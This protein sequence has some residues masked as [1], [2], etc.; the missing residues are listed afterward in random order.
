MAPPPRVATNSGSDNNNAA[1]KRDGADDD[2]RDDFLKFERDEEGRPINS[3]G[4]PIAPPE[5]TWVKDMEEEWKATGYDE[6]F[7]DDDWD[8]I[9]PANANASNA[10]SSGKKPPPE[11]PFKDIHDDEWKETGFS[12]EAEEAEDNQHHDDIDATAHYSTSSSS[13]SSSA[14]AA[15]A[16]AAASQPSQSSQSAREWTAPV[17]DLTP[18]E[19]AAQMGFDPGLVQDEEPE[20]PPAVLLAGF[21]AEEIPRIRELLDELGGHDVPVLPVP[22]SHLEKPLAEALAIPEPDWENPRLHERFNQGGEFGS[23][24]V[25]IFSGLDRGEMATV[26]SAV[27]A[28]GLPRLLTV[29]ITGENLENT[30]GEALAEA[31]LESRKDKKRREDLKK[32]DFLT[33]LKK[34]ERRAEAEGLTMDDMVR[35]E[36]ERQDQMAADEAAALA[37][38]NERAGRAEE[39]MARLKEEYIQRARAKAAADS[40]GGKAAP[41]DEEDGDVSWPKLED[42]MKDFIDEEGLDVDLSEVMAGVEQ[43]A[44]G[45]VSGMNEELLDA[46]VEEA[47]REAVKRA[48]DAAAGESETKTTAAPARAA[49]T[50]GAAAAPPAGSSTW[51]AEDGVERF[52]WEDD[53]TEE[54]EVKVKEEEVKA[55]VN[56]EVNDE[57]NEELKAEAIQDHITFQEDDED[58]DDDGVYEVDPTKWSQRTD[59]TLAGAAEPTSFQDWWGRPLALVLFARLSTRIMKAFELYTDPRMQYTRALVLTVSDVGGERL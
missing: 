48:E 2:E 25:V 12:W 34:M 30:M 44:T 54:E 24:R 36:I 45:D 39:H 7:F 38:R 56:D 32:R 3:Q 41:S 37:A 43:G 13:S 47:V 40:V 46:A 23:Q 26:V 16:A 27:E 10:V 20:G 58:D 4:V 52:T 59:D 51:G 11:Y 53:A 55:E 42:T 17:Q 33:E 31:V 28:R 35:R 18:S 1:E 21:R 29:V 49:E 22:Q 14:S 50:T 8:D 6:R 15:A 5:N 57:V 9:N 19:E